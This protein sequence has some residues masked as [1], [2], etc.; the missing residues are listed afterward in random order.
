[1]FFHGPFLA[2][3]ENSRTRRVSEMVQAR[4]SS[5]GDYRPNGHPSDRISE[6]SR[7]LS[8]GGKRVCWYTLKKIKA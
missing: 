2:D 1:M 5:Q 4:R 6:A 8:T 3:P 7:K